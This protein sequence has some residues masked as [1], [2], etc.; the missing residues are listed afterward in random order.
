MAPNEAL[1][2]RP[3][4]SPICWI[5]VEERSITGPDLI[6]DTFEKVGLIRKHL[7]TAQSR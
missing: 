5:E 6:R 3:C 2:G 7:L 4:Q 1:Y